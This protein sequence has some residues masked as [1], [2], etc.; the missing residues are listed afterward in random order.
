MKPN[1]SLDRFIA[2]ALDQGHDF[3]SIK[4]NEPFGPA[5]QCW[6]NAWTYAEATGLAY[7]EGIAQ[8]P[9]GWKA[10]AWCATDD[11]GVIEP[12]HRNENNLTYRGWVLCQDTIASVRSLSGAT[13]SASF[14]IASLD[15][16]A[17]A[18]DLLRTEITS[19]PGTS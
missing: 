13:P 7:A 10:H 18:W 12:T 4:G 15:T 11:G 5:D 9:F 8:T 14:L 1:E 17:V 16:N 6:S 19:I 2:L 3:P